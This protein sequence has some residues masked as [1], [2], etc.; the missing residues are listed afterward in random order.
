MLGLGAPGQ[1]LGG[2][3]AVASVRSAL[4]WQRCPSPLLCDRHLSCAQSVP[5]ECI[6]G[7]MPLMLAAPRAAPTCCCNPRHEPCRPGGARSGCGGRHQRPFQGQEGQH[8][9][10][11]RRGA[12]RG[13]RADTEGHHRPRFEAGPLTRLALLQGPRQPAAACSRDL[14]SVWAHHSLV[15]IVRAPDPEMSSLRRGEALGSCHFTQRSRQ[16]GAV[17]GDLK[18]TLRWWVPTWRS[19][20]GRCWPCAKYGADMHPRGLAAQQAHQALATARSTSCGHRDLVR[21]A[22]QI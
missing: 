2:Q 15:V 11:G 20:T 16:S 5:A 7:W 21:L 6:H 19:E 10:P 3:C 12:D 9:H 4:P 22:R 8:G 17:G 14:D 18:V 1:R 13:Q